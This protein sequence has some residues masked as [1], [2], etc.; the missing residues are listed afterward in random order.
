MVCVSALAKTDALVVEQGRQKQ[1][2]VDLMI[3]GNVQPIV[4]GNGL[5]G[6]PPIVY[7]KEVVQILRLLLHRLHHLRLHLRL[8]LAVLP[9]QTHLRLHRAIVRLIPS[10]WEGRRIPGT[11]IQVIGVLILVRQ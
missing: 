6:Q 10:R 4:I 2:T 8:L 1:R 5:M 9:P 3:K 11:K 7:S